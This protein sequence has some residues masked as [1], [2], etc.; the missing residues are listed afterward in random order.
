[1]GPEPFHRTTFVWA[2]PHAENSYIGYAY[3][4]NDGFQRPWSI[5]CLPIQIRLETWI[6]YCIIIIH[7]EIL[8]VENWVGY[9]EVQKYEVKI[10]ETW[11]RRYTENTCTPTESLA[12]DGSVACIPKLLVYLGPGFLHIAWGDLEP[13]SYKLN[14]ARVGYR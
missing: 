3:L 12:N 8:H 6:D 5:A 1:M 10:T 14:V 7:Y 4:L 2:A 13:R 11:L 9:L